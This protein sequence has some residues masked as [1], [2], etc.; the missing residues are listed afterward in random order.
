MVTGRDVDLRTLCHS[1]RFACQQRML[2]TFLG[3]DYSPPSEDGIVWQIS[4]YQYTM[5]STW[6]FEHSGDI[7][8]S[9]LVNLSHTHESWAGRNTWCGYV[10]SEFIY[11]ALWRTMI[12]TKYFFVCSPDPFWLCSVPG[13][14]ST[15]VTSVV[16]Y[17][18]T[19]ATLI[20]P[21]QDKTHVCRYVHSAFIHWALWR[22]LMKTKYFFVR[23]PQAFWLCSA[24]GVLSTLVTSVVLYSL[25]LSIKSWAWWNTCMW[26]YIYISTITIHY[27]F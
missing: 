22:I 27:L 4:I 23:S 3:P 20:S 2:K 10:C 19:Q 7:S 16:F 6:C 5:L 26:I 15:L 8:S 1:C 12:R 17:S 13:V 24:L 18:L 9:L 14:L 21:V 25:N 11:W